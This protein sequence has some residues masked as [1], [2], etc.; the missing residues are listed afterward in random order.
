MDLL[1]FVN[2]V[3]GCGMT[4]STSV[5]SRLV[6]QDISELSREELEKEFLSYDPERWKLLLF[7]SWGLASIHDALMAGIYVE[8]EKMMGKAARTMVVHAARR[9]GLAAARYLEKKLG[10]F[11]QE[12]AK[13]LFKN[14]IVLWTKMLGW[15]RFSVDRWSD[16]QI[17]VKHHGSYE[18]DGWLALLRTGQLSGY[19]DQGICWIAL[20]Y[21]WGLLEGLLKAELIGD[22]PMCRARG[23][24]FCSYVYQRVG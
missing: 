8:M 1:D 4:K 10:G 11:S 3:A 17:V 14:M 22:E 19:R 16:K 9:R 2:D 23:D 18:A 20:G 7:G 13:L 6:E 24:P 15:G 5:L 12:Q 21:I